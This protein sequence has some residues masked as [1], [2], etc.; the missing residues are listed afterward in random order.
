MILLSEPTLTMTTLKATQNYKNTRSR[1]ID[2]VGGCAT[3]YEVYT[4]EWLFA[5]IVV[6]SL[7]SLLDEE[8]TEAHTMVCVAA[9]CTVEVK[10]AEP[11]DR[12]LPSD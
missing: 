10:S 3:Y 7:L 5:S 6:L 12:V 4:M 1:F 11:V 8:E 9:S 2:G